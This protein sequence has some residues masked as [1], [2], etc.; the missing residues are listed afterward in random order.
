MTKEEVIDYLSMFDYKIIRTDDDNITFEREYVGRYNSTT[1]RVEI[2]TWFEI[3]EEDVL[4]SYVE[5]FCDKDIN[6]YDSLDV[7]D[8]SD[9]LRTI[10]DEIREIE[11]K[12]YEEVL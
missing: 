12:F 9:L 3:D 10:C 7:D 4:T 6:L 11:N 8:Y 1:L 2:T 5:D